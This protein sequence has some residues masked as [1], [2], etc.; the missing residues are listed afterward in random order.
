MPQ[1]MVKLL[2]KFKALFEV[3]RKKSVEGIAPV[4]ATLIGNYHKIIY[5]DLNLQCNMH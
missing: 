2:T 4:V 5:N 1:Q 3:M